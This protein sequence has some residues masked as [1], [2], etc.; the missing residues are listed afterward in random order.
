MYKILFT[1]LFTALFITGCSTEQ[2]PEISAYIK[3]E[4]RKNANE[5]M[6]VLKDVLVSEIQQNGLVAAFSVCSD[7]AQVMTNNYSIEKGIFIKRVSFNYRNGNNS[8]DLFET[9]GLSFFQS[10]LKEGRLDSLSEYYSIVEENDVKYL[11]YMKPILVQAPCLNC[12]GMET[13]IMPEV[14]SLIKNRYKNDKA[15]NYQIGELR[16]AVSIQKVF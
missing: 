4:M 14:L 15:K 10:I 6:S 7:T 5:F 9:Q 3:S 1:S 11:R 2:K 13:Q 8:P 16:G 12:H